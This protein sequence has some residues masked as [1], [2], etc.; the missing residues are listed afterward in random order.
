MDSTLQFSHLSCWHHIFILARVC[1]YKYAICFLH[2]TLCFSDACGIGALL[3][4]FETPRNTHTH[5]GG[6]RGLKMT[7]AISQV[8]ASP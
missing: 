7:L 1:V 8:R 6:K 3:T 2:L 5:K 4:A